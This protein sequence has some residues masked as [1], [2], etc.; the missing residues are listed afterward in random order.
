MCLCWCS[1]DRGIY[2]ITP[3]ASLGTLPIVKHAL[4]SREYVILPRFADLLSSSS[5]FSVGLFFLLPALDAPPV[6]PDWLS[7]RE[8]D[9]GMDPVGVG[10]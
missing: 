6:A 3:D 1:I 4:Q 2:R 5:S 9:A 10:A 7:A 8:R